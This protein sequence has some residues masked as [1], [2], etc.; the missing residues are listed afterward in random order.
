MKANAALKHVTKGIFGGLLLLVVVAA[1]IIFYGRFLKRDAPP[2]AKSTNPIAF[3]PVPLPVLKEG[4]IKLSVAHVVNPRL[5]KFSDA[6]IAAFLAA[7]KASAKAQL[8]RDVEFGVVEPYTLDEYFKEVPASRQS[9]RN[10]VIVDFKTGKVDRQK[11]EKAYA[12]AI[13]WQSAPAKDWAEYAAREIGLDRLDTDPN[14]WKKRLTDTQLARLTQIAAIKA[15][16]GKPV[17]DASP[18]NE[19]MFWSSVGERP[20]THDLIITNQLVASAEYANVDIHPALRGGITAGTTDFATDAQFGMQA[21]WSTFP[22]T[23]TDPVIVRMRGGESYSPDEAARIA[24][25]SAAHEF[26][27]LLFQYGHPFGDASCL[28]S[29]TPMLRFKEYLARLDAAK[30]LA[31]NHAAMKP[32]SGR[33]RKPH[34]SG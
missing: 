5:E 9:W 31:A 28:M 17:I 21:W 19:W 32:G 15:A 23:S 22:F 8:G 10:K 13:A 34:Y 16:D 29:P 12:D 24:G 26:G 18:Y 25:A 27:H 1:C 20:H 14:E 2:A 4:V 3:K 6:Q 11:L 33:V 30:C 7:L